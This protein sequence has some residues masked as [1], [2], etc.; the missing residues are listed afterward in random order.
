MKPKS[1]YSWQNESKKQ[2]AK[3][4]PVKTKKAKKTKK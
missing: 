1:E 4:K 3:S 2:Q